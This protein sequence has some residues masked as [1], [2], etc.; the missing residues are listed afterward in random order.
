M[1][2]PKRKQSWRIDFELD[3]GL[4]LP[5]PLAR[6]EKFASGKQSQHSHWYLVI[7]VKKNVS[8]SKI[9]LVLICVESHFLSYLIFKAL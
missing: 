2:V 9:V 6:M 5:S 4:A 1:L 7:G 8:F 3:L